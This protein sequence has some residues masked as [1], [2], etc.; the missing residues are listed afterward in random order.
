VFYAERRGGGKPVFVGAVALLLAAQMAMP[1]MLGSVRDIA[2]FLL[3][4]FV[5]FNVLEAMLPSLI[6]KVAPVG[7]RGT[8]TGIYS[9]IQFLGTFV[10]A[11]IGGHL[12]EHYGV[13]VFFA[14]L[15]SLLAI[16]L[17]LAVGMRAPAAVRTRAY[18]LPP[19]DERAA[20]GLAA[21]LAGLS[22][23]RE[24]LVVAAEGRAYLKVDA[25]AFDEENVL[26]LIAGDA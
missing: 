18:P 20:E 4:F 25:V 5:A 22:G 14:A 7:A 6:S 1:W 10:G 3:A 2:L 19:L 21:R 23:V 24:V 15:A 12:Y 13:V 11:A 16:W 26:R 9:S 17:L 8:A